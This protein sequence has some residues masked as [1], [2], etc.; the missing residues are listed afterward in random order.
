MFAI[1]PVV[2]VVLLQGMVTM[3]AILASGKINRFF[4][5]LLFATTLAGASWL[6]SIAKENNIPSLNIVGVGWLV[7]GLIYFFLFVHL[8]RAYRKLHPKKK[9]AAKKP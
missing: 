5:F 3:L 4:A 2:W 6:L 8:Q 7:I 1:N 9:P